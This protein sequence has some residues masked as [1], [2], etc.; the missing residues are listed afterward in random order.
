VNEPHAAQVENNTIVRIIRFAFR[1]LQSLSPRVAARAAARIFTF[2]RRFRRPER[3]LAFLEG[4]VPLRVTTPK[5]TIATWKWGE[6]EETILL[7][8]GWEGRGSQLG[9]LVRPLVE[10]GYQVVAFDAPG[11]GDSFGTQTNLVDFAE[12]ILLMGE[13]HAR[14]RAVVAHSFG[15]AATTLALSR[16]LAIDQAVFVAPPA[17]FDHYLNFFSRVFGLSPQ[18]LARMISGFEA[19]FSLNWSALNP[20]EQAPQ[21]TVPLLVFHDRDD[22][23]IPCQE[24]KDLS[25]SWPVSRLVTT[26]GLGHRRILR[27]PRVAA[28]IASVIENTKPWPHLA[29]DL[30]EVEVPIDP[31]ASCCG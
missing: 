5:G 17:R 1:S 6:S 11:H 3:E 31:V 30:Q 8:H 24:G 23:E 25:E 14:L 26:V 13:E 12:L 9:A 27:N 19:K 21:M 4:A 28:Q 22:T 29:A 15:A 16:G 7:V 20:L 18:T 10:A 2:P